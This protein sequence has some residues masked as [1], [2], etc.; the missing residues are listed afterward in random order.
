MNAFLTDVVRQDGTVVAD[1][2]TDQLRVTR[3][4]LAAALRPVA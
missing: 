2:L 4:E 1:R 3:K